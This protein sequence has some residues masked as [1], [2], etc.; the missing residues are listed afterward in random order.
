MTSSILHFLKFAYFAFVNISGGQ[1]TVVI[2]LPII[3]FLRQFDTLIW[4]TL[5]QENISWSSSLVSSLLEAMYI[6]CLESRCSWEPQTLNIVALFQQ[7]T[8]SVSKSPGGFVNTDLAFI[9]TKCLTY[10]PNSL[11][12][13]PF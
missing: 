8:A 9:L 2:I 4:F 11:N 10:S 12:D 5:V 6:K 7:F 3:R 13:Q 1:I